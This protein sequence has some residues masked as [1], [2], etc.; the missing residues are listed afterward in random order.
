MPY[1]R[2]TMIP[3]AD[4]VFYLKIQTAAKVG[5]SFFFFFS[6]PP[7]FLGSY[8][9]RDY[10]P[11]CRAQWI[12]GWKIKAPRTYATHFKACNTY[13]TTR[14]EWTPSIKRTGKIDKEGIR[15]LQSSARNFVWGTLLINLSFNPVALENEEQGNELSEKPLIVQPSLKSDLVT[16]E[17]CKWKELRGRGTE[18]ENWSF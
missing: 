7:T 18:Q 12:T 14:R 6:P 5:F 1:P 15:L 8:P 13:H 9:W 17:Q 16:S 3:T 2:Q 11:T 4:F 10:Y